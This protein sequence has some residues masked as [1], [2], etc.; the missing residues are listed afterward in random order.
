LPP[1]N[2]VD[3]FPSVDHSNETGS[4]EIPRNSEA[5]KT[6]GGGRDFAEILARKN[7]KDFVQV[8]V[9]PNVH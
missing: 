1:E 5:A 7:G 8:K 4:K 6:E 3:H 9:L 2:G